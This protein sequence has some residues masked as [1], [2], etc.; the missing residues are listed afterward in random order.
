MK[1][2]LMLFIRLYW[3]AIP[4]A[5]RRKCLFK[6]SC[7]RYVYTVTRE[8]GL[9]QGLIAFRYR[10]LNCRGGFQIMDCAINGKIMVLPGGDVIGAVD[11]AERF[12]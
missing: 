8:R 4:E 7:S 6:T 1:Y 3:L 5:Q 10:F 11:M 9:W 12:F 2:L